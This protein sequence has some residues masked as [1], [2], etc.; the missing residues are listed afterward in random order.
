MYQVTDSSIWDGRVYSKL[1]ASMYRWHQMVSCEHINSIKSIPEF[2]LLGFAC[3]VGVA[4]NNGRVGAAG[5]PDH[6][7]KAASSLAW[8]DENSSLLDVGTIYP[9]NEKL[10][11]AQQE[12]GDTVNKLLKH[13]KKPCII[14]GGHETAFGHYLGLANFLLKTDRSAKLGI[15]NIDAHFDLRPFDEG[16]H[17]GSPFL[18]AIHHANNEA[19][20]LNYFVHGINPHNNTKSLFDEAD[21][22]GVEF[23][24]NRDVLRSDKSAKK[25]L[26][27]FLDDRTHIYLT[28][29]LDVFEASIAPGVSA[30]AWNGIRLQS[31]L[32]VIRLVKSS[33]KL[34]SMDI[35][36]LN[37][38]FD[39]NNRTAKTAGMLVAELIQGS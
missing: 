39:V 22:W 17:S 10:D 14:G 20:D 28:I 1:D 11:D 26:R 9:E 4:R 15:L 30:P 25:K 33:G 16:A 7:R 23:N 31:A 12:L 2:A 32:D 36:E 19:L 37:P 35:C 27:R 24:T 3:D 34:L 8:L 38:E 6:F 29:C 21:K 18:Q 5:G 13:Q